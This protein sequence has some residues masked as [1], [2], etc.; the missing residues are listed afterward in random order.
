MQGRR[1]LDEVSD[2]QPREAMP[3]TQVLRRRAL[4]ALRQP[5][6]RDDLDLRQSGQRDLDA[7]IPDKLTQPGLHRH[8]REIPG[9]DRGRETT[10]RE[11]PLDLHMEMNFVGRVHRAD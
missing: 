5:A 6:Q 3:D 1:R 9:H 11:K 4:A 10:L 7:S 8:D 2:L